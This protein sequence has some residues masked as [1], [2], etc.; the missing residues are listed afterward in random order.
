MKNIFVLVVNGFL[1]IVF[2]LV[3]T[4]ILL[5]KL[6]HLLYPLIRVIEDKLH[7]SRFIGVMNVI[8]ISA[9]VMLILGY[10][11][12]LLLKSGWIKKGINR[13]EA[14]VLDKIPVYSIVKSLFGTEVGIKDE[15]NFRPAALYDG[16]SYSLCYVTNESDSFYTVFVCEGGL[17]GGELQIVTK[18][19]VTLLDLSLTEFTR[20]VKKYGMGSAHYIENA[21]KKG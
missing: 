21:I 12:G 19:K 1:G 13:F 8:I 11:C 17:G 14:N 3:M 18:E 15:N 4:I 16:E 10:L 20:M 2:P 9:V 6:H 7:I 5:E